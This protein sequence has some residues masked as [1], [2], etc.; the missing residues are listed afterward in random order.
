MSERSDSSLVGVAGVCRRN[1]VH[2]MKLGW[3][4]HPH[5]GF[6]SA[7]VCWL[8]QYIE[9]NRSAL[10]AE[11]TEEF[12]QLMGC[13]YGECL[14]ET[15]GGKWEWSS[16]QLGVRMDRLGFTYPFTAVT[17]RSKTVMLPRWQL[18]T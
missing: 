14:I 2:V 7:G 15:F 17:G 5:I 10:T 18:R 4:T 6:D 13:F 3:T 12:V 8:D 11:L 9:Q 16:D 1:A